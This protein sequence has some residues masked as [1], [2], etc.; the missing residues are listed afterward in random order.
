MAAADVGTGS[1]EAR[2]IHVDVALAE[3]INVDMKTGFAE[4]KASMATR[5]P[6]VFEHIN[7]QAAGALQ[8]K[9][10]GFSVKTKTG[11][12]EILKGISGSLQPGALTCILGP[13]GSGKTTLL[14]ILSGRVRPGGR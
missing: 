8:W 6:C 1:T 12:L 11:R 13:S 9:D 14:N 5:K 2:G 4:G 7:N 3:L 10:V